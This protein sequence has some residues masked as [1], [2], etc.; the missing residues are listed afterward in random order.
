MAIIG[1]ILVL[2]YEG[3]M[4]LGV[5][6]W[7]LGVSIWVLGVSI[8]V[9]GVSMVVLGVSILVLQLICQQHL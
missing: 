6:V 7:L 5:N 1:V 8:W 4:H 3:R 9:L 2:H